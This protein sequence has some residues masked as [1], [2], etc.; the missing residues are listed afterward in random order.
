VGQVKNVRKVNEE[1]PAE[2]VRKVNEKP[3]AESPSKASPVHET[4]LKVEPSVT[5]AFN[6]RIGK[7]K[8]NSEVVIMSKKD[9][10]PVSVRVQEIEY[11]EDERIVKN[12]VGRT[13][14]GNTWT[15]PIKEN[16][17]T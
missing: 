8:E 5:S 3:P 14:K 12:I 13:E 10:F 15:A 6:S 9:S 17:G 7:V 4:K 2:D 1:P 11:L 16:S